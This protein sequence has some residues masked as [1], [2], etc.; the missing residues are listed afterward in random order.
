MIS[1]H[2]DEQSLSHSLDLTLVPLCVVSKLTLRGGES[3]IPSDKKNTTQSKTVHD[4]GM[5]KRQYAQTL[6]TKL[7]TGSSISITSL[8]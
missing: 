4:G 8:A 5:L 6:I 7:H 2:N 3:S 1:G